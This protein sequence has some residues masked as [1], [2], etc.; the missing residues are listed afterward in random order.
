MNS[1]Q[2]LRQRLRQIPEL[3]RKQDLKQLPGQES[4]E[5]GF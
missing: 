4:A 2:N 3:I 5:G 1:K